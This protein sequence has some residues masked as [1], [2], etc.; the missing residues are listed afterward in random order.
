[1]WQEDRVKECE[2]SLAGRLY[3]CFVK[4]HACL[5]PKRTAP[6]QYHDFHCLLIVLEA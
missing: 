3:I 4:S 5:L 1:M 2:A 6:V